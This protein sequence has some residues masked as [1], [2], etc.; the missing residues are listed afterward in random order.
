MK[1]III[2]GS[3]ALAVILPGLAGCSKQS[4]DV[5]SAK[6]GNGQ[7]DTTSVKYVTDIVPIL[8][9]NCYECHGNSSN[10]GSGGIVLEG[11]SNLSG[12]ANNGYLVGCVTHARGYVAMPYLLPKLSDCDV[13][14]I[15]A[16]V[17]QG[18]LNN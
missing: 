14:K 17:H 2:S 15:V 1:R 12:W 8:Q 13:N 11:Y 10:M 18:S 6:A 16:W 7:C 5:F 4:E 3:I 9:N